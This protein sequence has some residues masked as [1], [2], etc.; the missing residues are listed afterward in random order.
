MLA[1]APH[2][3]WAKYTV[4]RAALA[5]NH[6]REGVER[7]E[8]LD[9]RKPHI[10]GYYDDLATALHD[11]GRHERELEVAELYRERLTGS[12]LPVEAHVRALSALGRVD[13]VRR[14]VASSRAAS[15]IQQVSSP[16][17]VALTASW[18]LAAHG[19]ADAGRQ[20]AAELVA[21]LRQQPRNDE[22]DFFIAQA[23][24]AAGDPA[25]AYPIVRQLLIAQS[26]DVGYLTLAGVIAAIMGNHSDAD[27]R[28]SALRG[29]RQPYLRGAH[30]FGQAAIAAQLGDKSGAVSLLREAIRQGVPAGGYGSDANWFFLPL[31]GYAPYE[32]LVK[33]Q[34]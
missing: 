7:L 10:S 26:D 34:G 21:W 20:I 1:V 19:H 17:T 24:C 12:L 33:P 32:E 6:L 3:S 11:L 23:L 5:I 28:S 2:S 22:N 15:S 16:T 8:G 9:W 14:L 18:E 13:A 27:S 4:A 31:H 25:S 30:I 29:L